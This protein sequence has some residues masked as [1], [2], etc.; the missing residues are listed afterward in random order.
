MKILTGSG[1]YKEVLGVSLVEFSRPYYWSGLPLP[2]PG[3][4]PDPGTEPV[5]PAALA[6]AGGF[7]TT[8]PPGKPHKE[9]LKVK[10]LV[11]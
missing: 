7:F 6:L 4:L 11:T 1:S 10:M 2:P 9:G 5:S 8:E 3:D